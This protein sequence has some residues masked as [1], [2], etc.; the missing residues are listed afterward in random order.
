MGDVLHHKIILSR[1]IEVHAQPAGLASVLRGEADKEAVG[2]V[3]AHTQTRVGLHNCMKPILIND[4]S[5]SLEMHRE[6]QSHPI[7]LSEGK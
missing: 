1:S 7:N 5:S 4:D 3:V 2:Q 6:S